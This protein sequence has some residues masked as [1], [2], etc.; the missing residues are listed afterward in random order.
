MPR[1]LVFTF[2][3]PLAAFGAVAVGE[4]RT[5]WDRPGKSQ[6]IG[7]LA[8]AL[9]IQRIEE[10]R[11]EDLARDLKLAIR[12]DDAGQL[13]TDYHTTQVPPQRRNRRFATR[14]EELAV[15]KPEL[16]TSLSRREFR[17]G[18]R[19]TIAVWYEPAR[20]DDL[21]ELKTALEGPCFVPYAGR[22]AFPLMLPMCP[23]EVM[24][25]D[26][27]EAT[28]AAYDRMIRPGAIDLL[29]VRTDTDLPPIFV[30]ADATP[31]QQIA[32]IE[33]RR[34]VPESRSKWR[35]GLRAEAMLRPSRTADG[36]TP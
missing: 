13:A 25:G 31:T 10:A 29:R 34:D 16:K 7:L 17:V 35:F 24:L 15:P 3:A 4:R 30:D 32:R 14:A 9:G 8:S 6:I 1:A 23:R 36:G 28:F 21:A 18:S 19:Y 33:E 5:T 20:D 11:L 2:A 22:K 26:E 12:I 27:I